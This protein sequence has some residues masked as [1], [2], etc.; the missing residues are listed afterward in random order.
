MPNRILKESICISRTIN[1]LAPEIECLFY[2]ILVTCDDFGAFHSDAEIIKARC[3]TRKSDINCNQV[4]SWLQ[5]L[6]SPE[7]GLIKLYN[8]KGE[9][10]LQVS[11]WEEH[12]QIR[13]K[14]RKFPDIAEGEIISCEITTSDINCNQM[15]SD[16][17]NSTRNPIQS[18]PIQTESESE[19]ES[20][21][22]SSS[23]KRTAGCGYCKNP[24]P[25]VKGVRFLMQ[26]THDG[27]KKVRGECPTRNIARDSKLLKSLLD[28]GKTEQDIIYRYA[29]YLK[30]E[31]E[32]VI[33]NGFNISIFA[34]RYDSFS[35]NGA[36]PKA[37]A[38]KSRSGEDHQYYFEHGHYKDEEPE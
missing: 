7:I 6:A 18:N 34:S 5:V 10:Y 30:S 16:V 35:S 22:I 31:D 2:R 9:R 32:F 33:S 21:P 28:N 38:P 37:N 23:R 13:A 29:N 15:I 11:N 8:V 25:D 3:L 20:N 24:I 19:S 4:E 27:F 26:K 1:K 17:S 14:R 12:Q 36:K